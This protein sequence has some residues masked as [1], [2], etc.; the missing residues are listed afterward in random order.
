MLKNYRISIKSFSFQGS[1]GSGILPLITMKEVLSL[2]KWLQKPLEMVNIY[3]KLCL[4]SEKI[5]RD[6]FRVPISK[7]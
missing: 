6:P 7:C 4:V 1:Q 2:A 3:F 5:M